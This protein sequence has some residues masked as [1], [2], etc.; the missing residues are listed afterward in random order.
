MKKDD[1]LTALDNLG[2]GVEEINEYFYHFEY[3]EVNYL[4]NYDEDDE[5][6]LHLS[7]P[8]IFQVTEDN[9]EMVMPVINRANDIIKYAKIVYSQEMVW[10]TFEYPLFEWV[11]IEEL[12]EF[13]IR[14]L[15]S[16]AVTFNRVLRG[17]FD[18]KDGGEEAA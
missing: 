14:M 2:F 11:D 16:A 6:F 17:E 5:D 9:A 15:Q 8:A 18:N 4:Y 10:A 1:V 13:A 3:E 7:I 12:L